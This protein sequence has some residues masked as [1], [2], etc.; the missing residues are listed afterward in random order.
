MKQDIE[1]TGHPVLR[2]AMSISG[3]GKQKPEELDVF[4]TLRHLGPDGKEGMF[5]IQRPSNS[6]QN[7]TTDTIFSL[8]YRHNR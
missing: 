2:V 4:I 3:E 5:T 1:V 7:T 6:T 8:L